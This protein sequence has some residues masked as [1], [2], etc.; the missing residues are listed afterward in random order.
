MWS[1]SAEGTKEA[2]FSS[3][4]VVSQGRGPKVL[5][6]YIQWRRLRCHCSQDF[7]P[8]RYS[9]QHASWRHDRG[10]GVA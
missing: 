1:V 2:N 3:R 9:G 4:W 5:V 8:Q 7:R 6:K 10:V